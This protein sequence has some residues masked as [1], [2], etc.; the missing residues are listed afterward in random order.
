LIKFSLVRKRDD[1]KLK[2]M[3]AITSKKGMTPQCR[4]IFIVQS[5]GDK[6]GAGVGLL[7]G[8]IEL[9]LNGLV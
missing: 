2:V 7:A 6:R 3:T 5:R 1:I 9:I 4:K 8:S